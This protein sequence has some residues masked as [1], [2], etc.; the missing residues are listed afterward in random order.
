M[1]SLDEEI[2]IFHPLRHETF[3]VS[4]NVKRCLLCQTFP[5]KKTIH[6]TQNNRSHVACDKDNQSSWYNANIGLYV[7]NVMIF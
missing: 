1:L 4:I 7:L 2:F 3:C 6:D 5:N